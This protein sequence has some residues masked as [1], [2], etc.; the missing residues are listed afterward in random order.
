MLIFLSFLWFFAKKGTFISD[1]TKLVGWRKQGLAQRTDLSPGEPKMPLDK[2]PPK[3]RKVFGKWIDARGIWWDGFG[4]P[5]GFI[6]IYLWFRMP[7]FFAPRFSAFEVIN[8]FF[9]ISKIRW[10]FPRCSRFGHTCPTDMAKTNSLRGF[11]FCLRQLLAESRK[12]NHHSL[13]RTLQVWE[14]EESHYYCPG[15]QLD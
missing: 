5:K 2:V 12:Q 6:Y 1:M 3:V 9:G 11:V 14:E 10:D 8:G 15:K 13:I 7:T 4:R